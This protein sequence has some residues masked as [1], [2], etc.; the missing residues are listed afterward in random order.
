[1]TV[2]QQVLFE[3]EG[4]YLGHPYFVT[5]NAL[6]NAIARRVDERTRRALHVSHGVFVPGEFGE[7]PAEHS[8][9]GYGGKLGQSLPDVEAYEDLFVFRDAVH[10]WLLDS[11]PR[12]AHNTHDIERHGDRMAFAPGVFLWATAGAA[13][14]EAVGVVVRALLPARAG[15]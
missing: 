2:I 10:R 3:V 9:N 13:K 6:F 1:M 15:R 14:F 4:S 5:G 12:D 8:Q 11:R 7:Y